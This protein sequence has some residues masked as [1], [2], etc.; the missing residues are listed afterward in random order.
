VKLYTQGI[1]QQFAKRKLKEVPDS[2]D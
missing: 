2:C 1:R